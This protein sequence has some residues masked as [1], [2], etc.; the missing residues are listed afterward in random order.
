MTTILTIIFLIPFWIF[1]KFWS[2]F[3]HEFDLVLDSVSDKTVKIYSDRSFC[4]KTWGEWHS[5]IKLMKILGIIYFIIFSIAT[6]IAVVMTMLVDIQ[7]GNLKTN[8]II[9]IMFVV[10]LAVAIYYVYRCFNI[11]L[12]VDYCGIKYVMENNKNVL[13]G[14]ELE[15]KSIA[16]IKTFDIKR[17]YPSNKI[18]MT[19][20]FRKLDYNWNTEF[21]GKFDM[22][23]SY[24]VILYFTIGMV[25][26]EI[27][28]RIVIGC[29]FNL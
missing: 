15:A 18:I 13:S 20:E 16:F 12:L 25:C 21:T 29:L 17:P 4:L 28:V 3:L 2:K 10:T 14:C 11:F 24:Y 23:V 26:L 19:Y 5:Q 9:G 1:L 27:L 7:N 8:L 22:L 6:Q